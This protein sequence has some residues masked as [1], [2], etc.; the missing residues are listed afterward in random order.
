LLPETSC[1]HFNSFLDRAFI[2]GTVEDRELGFF[3]DL[4]DEVER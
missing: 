3:K 1:E 4:L 2:V